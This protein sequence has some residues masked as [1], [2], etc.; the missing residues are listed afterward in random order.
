MLSKILMNLM[1]SPKRER[2]E[3]KIY[4]R[5]KK[6]LWLTM[7]TIGILKMNLAQGISRFLKE[8]RVCNRKFNNLRLKLSVAIVL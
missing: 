3:G 2:L 5:N 7:M 6:L 4:K 1:S 8:E